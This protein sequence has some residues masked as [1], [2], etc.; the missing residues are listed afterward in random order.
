[1]APTGRR[2]EEMNSTSLLCSVQL[3][4]EKDIRL[5]IDQLENQSSEIAKFL[6]KAMREHNEAAY[7]EYSDRL[8][9]NRGKTEELLW[10]LGEKVGQ[11]VLDLHVSGSLSGTV[12]QILE[13]LKSGELNMADLPA[14]VQELVRK[15]ALEI[16][17]FRKP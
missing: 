6:A 14:D 12:R 5:R 13:R 10:V 2:K 4:P 16:K 9:S 11:S 15:G 7:K 8:A 3:R 17:S 1:M